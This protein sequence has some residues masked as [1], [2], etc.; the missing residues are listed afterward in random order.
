M[1][2]QYPGVIKCLSCGVVLVSNWRHDFNGC[3]CKN[4]TFI[5]GGYD[6]LRYGGID[7]KLIE[8]LHLSRK[9]NGKKTKKS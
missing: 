6:Y 2:R 5:D 8:V 3:E 9:R 1:I 4:G 7:L